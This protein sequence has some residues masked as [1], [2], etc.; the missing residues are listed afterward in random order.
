[1]SGAVLIGILG[2]G[3][4]AERLHVPAL[5]R[6]RDARL[7][8]VCDPRAERRDLVARAAP[9]CRAFASAEALLAAR[10]VDA[11]VVASPPET[12]AELAVLSLQ[13]GLP[14][15]VEKP[16]APS[17]EE[18]A[19]VRAEERAA[20]VPV[21]VGFNRR[22]WDPAEALRRTLASAEE[23]AA[24]SV[25]TTIMSDLDRWGAVAG[26]LDPLDDLAVHHFDLLRYLLDREIATMR[27]QRIAA[28]EISLELTF[29]GGGSARCRAG[30][31][32]RSEERLAVG[33]K[34]H[35]YAIRAGSERHWPASGPVRGTVDLA[36]TVRRRLL[37]R[38]GGL[39]RSYERQLVAFVAAVRGNAPAT[40]GT[41]DGIAALQATEAAGRSL[42][43]GGT[44]VDVPP[45][46][47]T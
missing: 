14:V 12:H 29:H 15:L 11:V 6:L 23:D 47:T 36:D 19:W 38:R 39:A 26:P 16:L 17:L 34:G 46:P 44:E 31:G 27:A 28:Q 4:A 35:R 24:A 41:T 18:A 3:R 25:E 7:T 10:L 13:A 37:R 43:Q 20:R 45:T 40:P 42:E 30:F 21:M 9:G 2:C 32:G 8:A 33:T 5:A 22:W 1:M